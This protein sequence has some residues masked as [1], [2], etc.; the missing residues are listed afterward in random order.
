MA[1]FSSDGVPCPGLSTLHV[2][3]T[4]T[5]LVCI[6]VCLQFTGQKSKAQNS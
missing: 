3:T 5:H 6:T 2:L 4:L 1:L